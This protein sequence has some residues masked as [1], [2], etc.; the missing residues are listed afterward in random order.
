MVVCPYVAI[1]HPIFFFLMTQV[2]LIISCF[3]YVVLLQPHH[4]ILCVYCLTCMKMF[5]LTSDEL[6]DL[7][8]IGLPQQADEGWDSVTILDGHL[9]VIVLAIGDVAQGTTSFAVDFRFGVVEKPHQNRDPLQLAH[10]LLDLVIFVTQVLQVGSG[11][12][13]DRVDGVAQ[14]GDDLRKVWVTPA[15]VLTDA[16]NGG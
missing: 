2:F 15:R 8:V 13:L 3:R 4:M 9:V 12:G 5:I 10:I 1:L 11:V 16:V 7:H 14:H 6:S